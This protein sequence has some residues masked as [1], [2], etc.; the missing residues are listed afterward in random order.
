MLKYLEAY[1]HLKI[2]DL[3]DNDL[4]TKGTF[5]V[6]NLI[7]ASKTIEELNLKGNR[8]TYEGLQHLCSA[9][10]V[11]EGIV[12]IDISDNLYLD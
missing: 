4:G 1:D 2:L 12:M 11:N 3:S 7:T 9:L 8:I 6:C 10:S 5:D